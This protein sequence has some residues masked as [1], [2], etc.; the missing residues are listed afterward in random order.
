LQQQI[1]SGSIGVEGYTWYTWQDQGWQ[2][3]D[4]WP[5]K[6]KSPAPAYWQFAGLNDKSPTPSAT[7]KP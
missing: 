7:Q 3:S 2:C 1:V 6:D 4:L 5:E